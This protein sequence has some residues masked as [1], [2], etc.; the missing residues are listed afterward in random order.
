MKSAAASSAVVESRHYCYYSPSN[1][2]VGRVEV[3]GLETLSERHHFK[4]PKPSKVSQASSELLS[5]KSAV[6]GLI[7][8]SMG[9]II[10]FHSLRLARIWI[11]AGKPVFFY[12]A[13]EEVIE[14]LD[15]AR[16]WSF[17]T[18]RIAHKLLRRS[19]RAQTWN[20]L[21]QINI[22]FRK[23]ATPVPLKTVSGRGVSPRVKG[24]GVYLRTDYWVQLRAG[25]S[26]GH[27]CYVARELAKRTEDFSCLMASRFKLIDDFGIR[28]FVLAPSN[29]S[30]YAQQRLQASLF[31]RERL[32]ALL[33]Y[34]GP[35]YIYERLV[36]GNFAGAMLSNELRIPY[37]VE[38]NGSEISMARS[39]QQE[40]IEHEQLFLE[41]EL[42]AF[43]QATAIT[44]VSEIVKEQLVK[45]GVNPNKILVNPNGAD[46]EDYR[47]PSPDEK[48]QL[49]AKMGW[50]DA[51]VVIGFIG[52]FGGWHGIEVLAAALPR[53]CALGDNIKF[54]LIGSGNLHGLIVETVKAH[55]LSG[56]VALTGQIPQEEA[57]LLMRATDIFVSPHHRHMVDSKFFGSPTK[58]FEYMASGGAIVASD[59]E[60]IGQV[61]SPALRPRDLEN[62]N[63][64]VQEERAVLCKPGDVDEF[65]A[66]VSA[67]SRL[68]E[69][70]KALGANARR[71]VVEQY[72]WSEHVDKIL[73]FAARCS[74]S[75][76]SPAAGEVTRGALSDPYKQEAQRQ[77]DA[78]PCGAQYVSE[79]ENRLAF[80]KGVEEYRYGQY[81]PWM[82]ELMEFD[83]HAGAR[84]LEIG[85]G[86]GTDLAQFARNGAIVTDLDLAK[87]HMALAR[88]N[89]ELRGLKGEFVCGDAENIPFASG[90]FDLVYSNGVIHHI[91]QT[92]QVVSE[93]YRV[94]KPG[95]KAIIMVYREN[96]L[97]Y[98][99]IILDLGF[100]QNMLDE[101]SM[102]EIMSRNV[103]ISTSGARPLVK[104]YTSRQ[105]RDLF[106]NFS[107]VSIYRR[108]L[109][110]SE[111]PR[112]LRFV[113]LTQLERLIGWNL[114]VKAVKPRA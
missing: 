57:R 100:A 15:S 51:D 75:M 89:F 113:P 66:A 20:A 58:L 7:I 3:S 79:R 36:S 23:T 42:F 19:P 72:S 5:E 71:A 59:L 25:G 14:V 104:A 49:R 102:G 50:T 28:Q 76:D 114:I 112:W 106:K 109:V 22:L 86:I 67:L 80:F 41:A 74:E 39:F 2:T 94:L 61:L 54:L 77:W 16:W 68:E 110:T 60:Q 27:T 82:P 45:V 95:G 88:E 26:Y 73:D 97:Q 6:D 105:V 21:A 84:V 18:L 81:G 65:V 53:L 90:S 107:D 56:Q 101:W 13:R 87:G 108:Q 64:Q 52:T 78:D 17:F 91:P 1:G 31:Y 99:R 11:N 24:L 48:R 92:R 96:S 103:E 62:P 44:V 55:G 83:R 111:V 8:E 33:E 30:T 29:T 12:F 43:R 70:R 34:L 32:H 10:G 47:P 35:A 9:G 93:I 38:Y 69:V 85:S 37:I 98:W 46:V 40:A 4:L 63:L